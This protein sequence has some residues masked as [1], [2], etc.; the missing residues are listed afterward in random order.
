MNFTN[1][2]RSKCV[3]ILSY[4]CIFLITSFLA[5]TKYLKQVD[6]LTYFRI[7]QEE[8][9]FNNFK[10]TIHRGKDIDLMF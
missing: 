1:I 5:Q 9:Y 8:P 4:I 6:V 2:P 10:K 3:C 7:A